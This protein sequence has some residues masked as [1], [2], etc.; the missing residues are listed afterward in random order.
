M[1]KEKLPGREQVTTLRLPDELHRELEVVSKE[2][3]LTI[4]ALLIIGIW[5]SVLMPI[6][7]PQ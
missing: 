3:G 4:T 6:Q 5:H 2:T 7:K 1:E